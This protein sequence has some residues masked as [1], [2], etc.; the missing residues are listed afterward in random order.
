MMGSTKTSRALRRRANAGFTLTEM[1]AALAVLVLLTSMIVMGVSVGMKTYQASTFESEAEI[2]SST[3][4]SALS[5]PLR[6]ITWTTADGVRTYSIVY[7]DDAAGETL[8]SPELTADNGQIVLTGKGTTDSIPL[9]NK[10]AYGD[11]I[12]T[13]AELNTLETS[14]SDASLETPLVISGSYTIQSKINPSLT[15]TYTFSF[16]S[17][18]SSGISKSTS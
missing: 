11:C 16:V 12:V 17:L 3:I 5:D 18:F 7:R 6:T 10:G 15:H 14:D 8:E 1:L 2:L 4:N 13:N 9:L